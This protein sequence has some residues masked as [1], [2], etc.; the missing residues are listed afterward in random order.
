MEEQWPLMRVNLYWPNIVIFF[1]VLARFFSPTTFNWAPRSLF[2]AI[3]GHLGRNPKQPYFVSHF[4]LQFDRFNN[5]L[6][7]LSLFPR[8][9]HSFLPLSVA[10]TSMNPPPVQAYYE[11]EVFCEFFCGL[12]YL[13]NFSAVI[14]CS[15]TSNVPLLRVKRAGPLQEV[16]EQKAES[17]ILKMAGTRRK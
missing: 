1:F 4:N 2:L 16:R 10:L 12:Q 3:S 17:S 11:T 8:S 13:P 9:H 15:A 7:V 6:I 14:R 5:Q